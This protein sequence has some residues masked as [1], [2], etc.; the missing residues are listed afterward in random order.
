MFR[1]HRRHSGR[2]HH[3]VCAGFFC[4]LVAAPMR[5]EVGTD[6]LPLLGDASSSLISPEM[7]RQIGGQ[8]LKQLH[9]ALPT[10]DDPILK[11]WVSGEVTDLAQYSQLRDNLMQVV[12]IDSPEINA[13]AAPGGV[14]GINL[15]LM[16]AAEDVHEY[17]SVL[18]HELAHLSQRHF[19]RGV[20]EQRASTLPT[21]AS[22][23]AAIM[24]GAMGGGDAGIAAISAAQAASQSNQLRYSR[25]REQ[26]AD[27]IGLNTMVRAGMDPNGMSRMFERMQQAYRF[28]RRPPEFLLTHPLSESRIADTRQQ[29]QEYPKGRYEDSLDYALM[30]TR[31]IVYYADSPQAAVK[32]FEKEV[33]D[34]PDSEAARY[35]LALALSK[36]GEHEQ[37]IA[38]GD[39]LFTRDPRSILYVAAYAE[40][41]I[42]GDRSAQAEQLLAQNLTLNPDNAPLSILYADAL[43]KQ[44]KYQKAADVLVRQSRLR[45][46]DI[47]VWYDLAEVSGLAGDIVGVHRARAEFFGLHGAYQK[48]IAHLEYARRL[49][50]RSNTQLL[51]RLD[52]RID[53][54]RT[55]L[56]TAQ[57]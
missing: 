4:A 55:A 19:A 11:Y 12:L 47:D 50:D 17:S 57:S 22:L 5:A 8:F 29:V 35:G 15:G 46:D 43:T 51:A 27:R 3:F 23:I 44:E 30:R 25:T 26:E 9:A 10:I 39:A 38:L 16:L 14:V 20:E 49:T 37:A 42:N 54:F 48:A 41:L 33:R 1:A 7:E 45:K 31:A 32:R 40:L 36:A 28:S 24:V 56:R 52:Q 2:A 13:F 21:L 18:A 53:D 6:D 34:N